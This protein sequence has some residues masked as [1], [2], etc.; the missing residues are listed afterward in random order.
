M[1]KKE[2]RDRV[3]STIGLQAEAPLDESGLVDHWVYRGTLDLLSRTRCTARCVQL[4]VTA[5]VDTY[6]LASAILS[7]I[8]VDD[9]D[10]PRVRRDDE[11]TSGF[12][13]IRSDLLQFH[14]APSADGEIQVWAVLRPAPM[15][16]DDDDL[17]AEAFG[18]I[19]IEFQDAIELYALWW[20]ADYGHEAQ[21]QRGERYRA[22][23]EGQDGRSGRLAEIRKLVNK[24]GTARPPWT[25]K[26]TRARRTSHRLAWVD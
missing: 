6:T 17:G 13:L 16:N 1:T 24:R 26:V 8:D 20:A 25:R 23:Y 2:I 21:T 19:P 7:L 9:G 11:S 4:G 3:A 15:L 5:G 14:P 22:L 10:L 18:A 12:T